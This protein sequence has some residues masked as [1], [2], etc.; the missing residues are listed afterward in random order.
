MIL[1]IAR[2][3]F[4]AV[5]VV[6]ATGKLVGHARTIETLA[7]FGVPAPL[8]RPAAIALPLAELAIAVALLPAATAAWAALGATLLLAAFTSA[9]LRVLAR[10]GEVDC[11]CFG[12]VGSSRITRWTAVRNFLLLGIA[13]TV[14][15]AGQ[16]DPGPSAVAWIGDLD[17]SQAAAIGAGVAIVLATLNFAFFSFTKEVAD[18]R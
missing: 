1:L 5:F 8:R 11:N 10:G 4:A 9:V 15:I 14:G 2:L 6:A 3:A 17:T 12:P 16:F 7:E 13:A 18:G